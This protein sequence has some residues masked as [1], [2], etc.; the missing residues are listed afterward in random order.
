MTLSSRNSITSLQ[1]ASCLGVFFGL[2]ISFN[3][4]IRSTNSLRN[5]IVVNFALTDIYDTNYINLYADL[6]LLGRDMMLLKH[7][8]SEG[9]EFYLVQSESDNVYVVRRTGDTYTCSCPAFMYRKGECKHIQFVKRLMPN[10][11]DSRV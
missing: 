3:G 8:A 2:S 6:N 10:D 7:S 9:E 5:Q 11:R 1:E 4:R